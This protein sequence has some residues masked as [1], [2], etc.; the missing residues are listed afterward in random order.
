MKGVLIFFGGVLVG[1]GSSFIFVKKKLIPSLR[2][3]IKKECNDVIYYENDI[4]ADVDGDDDEVLEIV[5]EPVTPTVNKKKEAPK[6]ETDYTVYFSNSKKEKKKEQEKQDD[7]D[8]TVEEELKKK[9]LSQES[10][11]DISGVGPYVIDEGSFDEFSD[12]TAH[13]FLLFSDGIVIDDETEEVLD[14][15]PKLIFGETAFEELKK[16]NNPG[17]VYVRNDET[18]SDYC[19]EL[20]PYPFDGPDT[21]PIKLDDWG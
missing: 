14:A 13:T 1:I 3:E 20:R 8:K 2:E 7:E 18:K 10:E 12:Y 19:L 4:F 17:M 15:D 9:Y 6:P 5:N 21:P 16:P 11:T